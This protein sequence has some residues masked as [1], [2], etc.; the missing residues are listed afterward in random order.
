MNFFVLS[1][2]SVLMN[3]NMQLFGNCDFLLK[4]FFSMMILDYITGVLSAF[5]TK[6]LSSKL[7]TLGVIKKLGYIA[8]MATSVV[9]DHLT[10]ANGSLRNIVITSFVINEMLSVLENAT[11]LGVQL[12]KILVD[13]LKIF[14]DENDLKE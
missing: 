2:F 4:S 12:P 10:N 1:F 5:K 11:I 6:T 7:A 13:S 14:H 9:L 3:M 8:V